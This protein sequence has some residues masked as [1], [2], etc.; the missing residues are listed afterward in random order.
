VVEFGWHHSIAR[1]QKPP[2]IHKDLA[3]ISYIRRY[4]RFCPKFRCR[5][6]GGH[7]GVDLDDAVK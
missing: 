6:N 2:V 7:V 5:G 4:S 3:D 1:A